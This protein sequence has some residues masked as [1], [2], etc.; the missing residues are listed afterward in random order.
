MF[1]LLT[2]L[3]VFLVDKDGDPIVSVFTNLKIEGFILVNLNGI[4]SHNG[5]ISINL[6]TVCSTIN[7][8]DGIVSKIV[9][10]V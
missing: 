3:M 2:L 9:Q 10:V 5:S 7:K 4:V 8:F 6:K 1:F